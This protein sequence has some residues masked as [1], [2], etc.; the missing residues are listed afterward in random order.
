MRILAAQFTPVGR[1]IELEPTSLRIT[2]IVVPQ[3]TRIALTARMETVAHD[4]DGLRRGCGDAG[5]CI[6]PNDNEFDDNVCDLSA[7]SAGPSQ[8]CG[9][10]VAK[11]LSTTGTEMVKETVATANT[12]ETVKVGFI[13]IK[14]QYN[15]FEQDLPYPYNSVTFWVSM[16]VSATCPRFHLGGSRRRG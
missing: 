15:L 12:T 16:V 10:V 5:Q 9:M 1:V 3:R 7:L 8:R 11:A 4:P 14:I 2:T 13:K 6:G